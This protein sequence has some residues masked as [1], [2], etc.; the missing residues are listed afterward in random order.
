[1]TE[2]TQENKPQL[3]EQQVFDKLV[4]VFNE[5]WSLEQDIKEILDDAKENGLEE[6]PLLKSIAKAKAWNKVGDLE[7]KAQAQ[8]AKIE[9]YA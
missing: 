8:L 9:Q 5:I 6:L 2:T 4:T 7:A 1:M 3:T